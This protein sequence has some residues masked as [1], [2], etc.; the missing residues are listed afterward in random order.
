MLVHDARAL[1]GPWGV[2]GLLVIR[3]T[4]KTSTMPLKAWGRPVP[5]VGKKQA[6]EERASGQVDLCQVT[7]PIDWVGLKKTG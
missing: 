5:A 1:R 7:V 4:L 6:G 2:R 3:V